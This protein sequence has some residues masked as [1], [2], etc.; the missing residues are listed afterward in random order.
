MLSSL[1]STS[2]WVPGK[3]ALGVPPSISIASG[4]VARSEHGCKERRGWHA[5]NMDVKGVEKRRRSRHN[6]RKRL[7]HR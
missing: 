1:R 2:A 6:Q 4:E 5:L 3:N 7:T